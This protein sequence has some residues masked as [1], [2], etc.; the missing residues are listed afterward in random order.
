MKTRDDRTA[1]ALSCRLNLPALLRWLLMVCVLAGPGYA[2]ATR[3]PGGVGMC[4]RQGGSQADFTIPLPPVI[5]FRSG[6]NYS[7]DSPLYTGTEVKLDYNC[8]NDKGSTDGAKIYVMRRDE[9]LTNLRR[10]MS[11]MGL[12]MKLV[13]T[14]SVTGSKKELTLDENTG[15]I[16]Y[17]VMRENIVGDA[18]G[19]LTFRLDI[20]RKG[21]VNPGFYSLPSLNAFKIVP[22]GSGVEK[23]IN[24]KVSPVQLQYVPTCF[25]KAS[26]N[27]DKVDFGPVLTSDIDSSFSR[28]R[29]FS[30]QASVNNAAGCNIGTLTKP[31]ELVLEGQGTK[32]VYLHLPLKVAFLINSGG[33]PS[34]DN[35]A[36]ILKN[37]HNEDNGLQ[38][39]ISDP[40]GQFVT[41]NSESESLPTDSPA[42]KLGEFHDGI[43][44]V[45]KPYT[46]TL[47]QAPGKP[48]KTGKYRTQ[49]T[50]KVSYY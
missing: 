47:S 14:D 23:G 40:D 33:A 35:K 11:D 38:L 12:Y 24:V 16:S 43:F 28:P 19:T 4:T 21:D 29:T 2:L 8:S 42:N 32:T 34:S 36:I 39:K 3:G 45:N 1:F 17:V 41:F 44:T 49:V 26:L 7:T 22:N 5:T 25:V 10:A 13:V 46:A 50:V 48:V 6:E 27:T 9:E 15:N 18:E 20:Y 31:F 30:I 37:E